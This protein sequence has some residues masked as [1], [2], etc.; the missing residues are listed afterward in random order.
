[1][2]P[3]PL[4]SER[5][6]VVGPRAGRAK[7]GGWSS[8]YFKVLGSREKES[9]RVTVQVAVFSFRDFFWREAFASLRRRWKRHHRAAVLGSRRV[10][11]VA[12][13][14]VH[15]RVDAPLASNRRPSCVKSAKRSE[16]L[17]NARHLSQQPR[18][19]MLQPSTA[20]R[21]TTRLRF[22]QC[23]LCDDPM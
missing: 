18:L 10:G 6:V 11:R 9:C 20:Q 16:G 1:M 13:G 22:I 23:A 7:A 3:T 15:D 2:G 8:I 5:I 19:R 17:P 21:V 12:H 4:S 14:L